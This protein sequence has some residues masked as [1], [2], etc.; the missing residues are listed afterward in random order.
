MDFEYF[1]VIFLPSL[2]SENVC[3]SIDLSEPFQTVD[4]QNGTADPEAAKC[5]AHV[6][7][8]DAE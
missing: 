7:L 4:S 5:E 6:S 1:K 8:N 2:F 3:L